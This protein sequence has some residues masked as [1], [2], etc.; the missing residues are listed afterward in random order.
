MTSM[1]D[2]MSVVMS[3]VDCYMLE[4][5]THEYHLSPIHGFQVSSSSS[6]VF[7]SPPGKIGFYL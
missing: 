5:Y 7:D 2:D 1:G 4:R 6:Y 3:K